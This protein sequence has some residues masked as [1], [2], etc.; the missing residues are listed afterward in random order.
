MKQIITSLGLDYV[1]LINPV[2]N[3]EQLE[4]VKEKYYNLENCEGLVLYY[5]KSG[6]VVYIEKF[7]NKQYTILRT[8]REYSNGNKS[9]YQLLQ[10]FKN[11]HI[12]LSSEEQ[13]H[14][15]SFYYYLNNVKKNESFKE[16][17]SISLYNDF[18]KYQIDNPCLSL[19]E[20]NVINKV[21]IVLI[22]IPGSGK[23]TIGSQ[24]VINALQNGIKAVY[25]DQDMMFGNAKQFEEKCKTYLNSDYQL[26]INGKC[27]T[28]NYSRENS[29]KYIN[30]DT[31]L[32]VVKIHEDNLSEN[33]IQ[34]CV[35]RISNR[36]Y[37]TSLFANKAKEV[38]SK[39]YSSFENK[40][41]DVYKQLQFKLNESIELKV[42]SIFEKVYTA[43]SI[44]NNDTQ[45]LV[46][47]QP[48]FIMCNYLGIK[49]DIKIMQNLLKNQCMSEFFNNTPWFIKAT[50]LYHVTLLHST[51]FYNYP[52][53]LV[54]YSELANNNTKL[55]VKIE[56]LCWNTEIAAFKVTIPELKTLIKDH[57][58]H[59]TVYKKDMK[60]RN[61][62]SNNMLK[63]EHKSIPIELEIEG[64]VTRF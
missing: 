11:Y 57:T 49:M 47:L 42:S 22:G 20:K 1:E 23:T 13:K 60:V 17:F 61:V 24:L 36:N 44:Q 41:D 30:D 35:Q 38:V 8:I 40:I 14:F 15:L 2:S 21:Y 53:E 55:V 48:S 5:C 37:H 12:P 64:I 25:I 31:E 50:T 7:K 51:N 45:L 6:K 32:F 52:N 62:E 39:F 34:E 28:T 16:H 54:Y 3:K 29:L 18:L 46:Q 59:I 9:K 43:L 19:D 58:Y 10:R 56:A 63:S 4:I 27:N 26:I 33:D